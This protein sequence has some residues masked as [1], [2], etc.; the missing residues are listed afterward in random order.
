[1]TDKTAKMDLDENDYPEIRDAVTKICEGFPGQYWRDLEDQSI[2]GSSP[3]D[4]VKALKASGYLG[5]VTIF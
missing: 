5:V 4:F 3:T 2:E 1:M